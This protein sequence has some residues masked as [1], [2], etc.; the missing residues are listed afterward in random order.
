[1]NIHP[2]S[3]YYLKKLLANH[4]TIIFIEKLRKKYIVN[5]YIDIDFSD[6]EIYQITYDFP[7]LK[8]YICEIFKDKY[9]NAKNS[10]LAHCP[11]IEE[12]FPEKCP[13]E[14]LDIFPY[15][16]IISD[17]DIHPL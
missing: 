16:K 13:W 15:F 11:H 2:E 8:Y 17:K 1:M 4:L 3:E 5:D 14:I 6:I 10:I 9:E 7:E 12:E